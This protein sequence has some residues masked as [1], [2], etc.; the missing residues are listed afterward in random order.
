MPPV[1]GLAGVLG[2]T[3]QE[4][5]VHGVTQGT[6][7]FWGSVPGPFGQGAVAPAAA[8][9]GRATAVHASCDPTVFTGLAAL[10]AAAGL[11]GTLSGWACHPLDPAVTVPTITVIDDI[12]R[13]PKE[14]T[15]GLRLE[16]DAPGSQSGIRE[17]HHGMRL[18]NTDWGV[19]SESPPG[20]WAAA[21]HRPR[22]SPSLGLRLGTVAGD[23]Q[24]R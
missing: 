21:G 22:H 24:R 20:A 23:A 5:R 15:A 6:V 3:K 10:G 9:R 18:Q 7:T 11:G 8:S 13:E 2:G 14:P 17:V 4:P 19:L 16:E 1:Q 12:C